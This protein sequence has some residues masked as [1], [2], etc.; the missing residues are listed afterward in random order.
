MEQACGL[1]CFGAAKVHINEDCVGT[2]EELLQ[3]EGLYK[4]LYE[5]KNIDPALLRK[6]EEPAAGPPPGG[7][8][9]SMF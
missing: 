2:H 3:R 7:M 9:M 5:L 6:R 1:T 8:P 4:T